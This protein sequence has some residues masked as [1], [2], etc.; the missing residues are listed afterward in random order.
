M[1]SIS[2]YLPTGTKD[3][4]L[5]ISRV[6]LVTGSG[7]APAVTVLKADS[8]CPW[9]DEFGQ[10]NFAEWP[11]KVHSVEELRARGE[12]EA[13]E[14][15]AR[16]AA[17]PS[18][19]R[20][21]GWAGGP[22][23]KATGHFRTEKTGGR[24][25]FVDPDGHLFF[26]LGVNF[27]WER[28]PT[29]ITKR[30]HYFEKLPPET[31]ETAQFWERHT[32]P[33]PANHN[34][35]SWPENV[36]FKTFSFPS[37]NLY[38]KYG[39][40]WSQR[41]TETSGA[42]MRSWGLNTITSSRLGL[43][44]DLKLPYVVGIGPTS[45]PIEGAKGYWANLLDPYAPEFAESCRRAAR[46]RCDIGTNEYCIGWTSH[47]ELSWGPDGATL[48]R[49]VLDSPAD[50]PARIALV[51]F[52]EGKGLTPE[53]AADEDYRQFGEALADK[54]YSTVRAAIKEVAPYVLYL[55]DRNDKHNPETWR[56]A[57]RHVDV[58][59]VNIYDYRPQTELPPGSVDKPFMVTEFHFGT[60]DTGYFYASLLPVKDAR[61]V[62][63]CYRDYVGAAL[64][65]PNYIGA[66]W[67]CW[68]DCPITGQWNEGANAQC[69]LVSIAD[70]PYP[71]MVKAMR[72]IS[73]S[74][75]GRRYGAR[76]AERN[77]R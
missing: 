39:R 41:D 28:S 16:P 43:C 76:S 52:L 21:G 45:R 17:I 6:E 10:A 69:G 62:A 49:S 57:S 31:G 33:A 24:W 15:A 68:R 7:D 9:V 23:L 32:R 35:Y 38:L 40:D 74:M 44:R 65:N 4:E 29:G 14:Q 36:P 73:G 66:C 13:R 51:R 46:K 42:R 30:E 18:A 34:F 77:L 58:L 59:T 70:V 61:T 12:A 56:A 55:G 5:G 3:A 47:N 67:F 22:Q 63:D 11:D 25:W 2:I 60:Y 75:Y 53:N 72:E 19:D 37:H 71:E 64:D 26:A 20:F 1:R 8:L 50:Q 48:A 27:G 54:Y